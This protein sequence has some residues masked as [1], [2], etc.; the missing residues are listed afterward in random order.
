MNVITIVCGL[1]LGAFGAFAGAPAAQPVR[2]GPIV[3]WNAPAMYISGQPYKA[4][5]DITS[6]E[7]GTVIANWLLS[8]SAFTVDGKQLAK[9]EEGGT[10]N[11][12][13]GFHV[14]GDVD[15]SPYLKPGAAFKLGYASDVSDA[16]PVDVSLYELAPAGLDFMDAAKVPV[17]ELGKYFVQLRTN[18][19]DILLKLW[20]DVAPNHVR[21][22]LDLSYPDPKTGHAFYDGVTFHRVI[23][24]FMIQGGD[25]TGTGGGDGK[26]KLQ[27]EFN[28]DK[29]HV[30]G[31]LSMARTTDPNSASCQFFIMHAKNAGLD[32]QYSAFG[33]VV[34]GMDAVDKI[35]NAPRNGADKPNDPQVIQQAVVIKAVGS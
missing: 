30:R 1:T 12:P 21:N 11:L 17:A 31:V 28:K 32:G 2:G 24:G 10:I 27:A 20:P 26:R 3:E 13:A 18:R 4:H 25:P 6:P 33:E 29:H 14:S 5:V 8:P 9:R 19:G 22:F 7:G 35:A 23:P 16:K 34:T 15:L